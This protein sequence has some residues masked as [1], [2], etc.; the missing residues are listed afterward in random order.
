M[1]HGKKTK[2]IIIC[3]S[4][5]LSLFVVSFIGYRY[6]RNFLFDLMMQQM[7]S[8]FS[9][10]NINDIEKGENS[11]GVSSEK[12]TNATVSQPEVPPE[13]TEEDKVLAMRMITQKLTFSDI[14]LLM[15]MYDGGLTAQEREE[16]KKMAYEKFTPE[17][18]EVIKELY[19][20]YK[21]S[22]K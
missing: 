12:Q 9:E 20:K 4:V 5:C 8:M 3:L 7:G 19:N 6:A 10:P 11:S 2:V 17:E 15:S 14:Q 13:V 21:G 18:I 1:K 22:I 16:A